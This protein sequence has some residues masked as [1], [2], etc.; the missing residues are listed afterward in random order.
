MWV[1][2]TKSKQSIVYLILSL[3]HNIKVS[4]PRFDHKK[5]CSFPDIPF[6]V[7]GKKHFY[8]G[9]TGKVLLQ[10]KWSRLS[11]LLPITIPPP[12]PTRIVVSFPSKQFPNTHSQPLVWEVP[13]PR[14]L[15]ND[16]CWALRSDP[17]MSIMRPECL[18][19]LEKEANFKIMLSLLTPLYYYHLTNKQV[20][21]LYKLIRKRLLPAEAPN[22]WGLS[23]EFQFCPSKGADK[24][25]M[26]NITAWESHGNG[27]I[28]LLT[29]LINPNCLK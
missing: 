25:L 5:I 28:T 14:A 22:S 26:L 24:R 21:K 16:S 8:L 19:P 1:K 23:S 2:V 4:H 18:T 12:P 10:T 29:Q 9:F 17:Q 13:C 11:D 27:Q 3:P 6:L 7:I 20:M 15:D